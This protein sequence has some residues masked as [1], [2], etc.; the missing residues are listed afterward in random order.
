M[1]IEAYKKRKV[2]LKKEA[3]HYRDLCTQCL[4]PEFSCYCVHIKKLDPKIKF[5][6]L[7]HPIEQ[8]RR[9][10]T[11]RMSHL[12]LQNSEMIVGQD[13]TDNKRVNEILKN[14]ECQPA[15][16]YPG[17]NS[18]NLTELS[19]EK[20]A[21]LFHPEKEPVLFV[22]DGTWAT[23][24]KTM[25]ASQ[26]LKTL[27]QL[28]FNLPHKSRFRVRKQPGENCFSTIEAIHHFIELMG[29]HTVREH[30]ALITVFDKMVER[31]L[32]FI[33]RAWADPTL[34]T[35]RRVKHQIR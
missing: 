24:R 33:E 32:E 35:Y 21:V 18:L 26:N 3:Q 9:I 12:C 22:I 11:G 1:N 20:K 17:I 6:I 31:Q 4:Q 15:V 19:E 30:D 13:Y 23:A 28:S 14:P 2:Q 5:V 16:L 27:P 7:M 10:A 8:K 29:F 25:H 34:V